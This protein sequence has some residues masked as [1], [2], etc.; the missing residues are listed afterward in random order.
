MKSAKRITI[1]AL[2]LLVAIAC[3]VLGA[4]AGG[5]LFLVAGIFFEGTFWLRVFRR[6]KA[7][8]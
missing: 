1:T 8:V 7:G 6:R 4:E 5:A 3:Y 2:C